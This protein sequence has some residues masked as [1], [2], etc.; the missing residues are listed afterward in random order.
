MMSHDPWA[1]LASPL[2]ANTVSARRVDADIPWH[3]FWARD[4]SGKCMLILTHSTDA[5]T[6]GRLPNLKGI[7]LE[8]VPSECGSQQSLTF[9]LL[10]STH[11]E[12]FHRLC[13]DIVTVASIAPSELAAVIA[14]IQRT[15]RWHHLLRGGS[16]QRLSEEEQKGLIGELLTIEKYLLPNYSA[17]VA[18]SAWSGPY[19]AP[20]DFQI[21]LCCIETKAHGSSAKP[22]VEITSEHQLDGNGLDRLF[23]LIAALDPAAPGSPGQ[24]T[25]TEL[26]ARLRD[27]IMQADP[28][29]LNLYEAGLAA[30]GF[31]GEDD[32][33]EYAWIAGSTRLY[34]VGE[35]FPR[36]VASGMMNGVHHVRYSLSLATCDTFRIADDEFVAALKG[37]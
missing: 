28:A 15:W 27:Q 11:R 6:P 2:T 5:T 12:I 23:L 29:A 8:R 25:L 13:T 18:I 37:A 4:F 17:M 36:L 9:R 26:V 22:T 20:K 1:D 30:V 35:H 34:S 7:Q 3:F 21:G 32:Y 14:T 31:R 24:F 10:D 19:G 33:S 16:Q